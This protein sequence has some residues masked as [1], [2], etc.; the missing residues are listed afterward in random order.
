MRGKNFLLFLLIA[1]FPFLTARAS[2]VSGYGDIGIWGVFNNLSDNPLFQAD[3]RVGKSYVNSRY[4]L[5]NVGLK[6]DGKDIF[7]SQGETKWNTHIK[8][9]GLFALE[10][11]QYTLAPGDRTRQE[12]DELNLEALILG[13][14]AS[15]WFGRQ[16]IFEAGGVTFDGLRGVYHYSEKWDLGLFGGLGADPRNL[17]GYIGP[18]YRQN[19]FTLDFQTM[20][21]YSSY[22]AGTFKIDSSI[23]GNI[24]KQHLD[25]FLLYSQAIYQLNSVWNFSGSMLADLAS[26]QMGFRWF[27]AN[28]SARPTS[29]VTNTL[30]FDRYMAL[31]YKASDASAIPVI[32]GV[33]ATL[34][35]GTQVSESTVNTV[36]G[37]SQVR[38]FAR[39]Y[40]FG[41]V[42]YS[43][44]TFDD[45]DRLKYTA[46][47]RDPALFGTPTDIRIQMDVF[48]GYRGFYT[49]FDGLIGHDFSQGLFRLEGGGTFYS[50][51][52]DV[53]FNNVPMNPLIRQTEKEYAMRLNGFYNPS[54]K[55]T[56][57]LNY[58]LYFENDA[59]NQDQG[60][61]VHE[62]YLASHFRF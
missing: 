44:E 34:V 41:S 5:L 8:G 62:I 7:D 10:D 21:L 50:N 37:E 13:G 3:D 57:M 2:D 17:T 14:D 27:Q 46:G 1:S 33:D 36:R 30:S 19:P 22:R 42:E 25:Q 60:V 58:A 47:Y 49:G 6:L 51:E 28:I 11:T 26:G 53:Y 43:R 52:R 48:E 32:P 35:G 31:I 59:T 9:R 55:V 23:N 24:Y 38:I 61:N 40:I 4:S 56:W 29:R 15:I 39:N 12:L 45:L 16:Q 54:A 18:M 20:G